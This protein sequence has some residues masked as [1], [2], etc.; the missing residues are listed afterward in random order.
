MSDV[1]PY[2]YPIAASFLRGFLVR[3][4]GETRKLYEIDLRIYFDWCAAAGIDPLAARRAD[5]ETFARYLESERGNRPS[6]VVHRLGVLRM[7][8]RVAAADDMITRDPTVL[9]NMPRAHRDPAKLTWLDRYEMGRMMRVASETSPAHEALVALMGVLG[10]RVSEACAV[11]VED[12]REEMGYRVL[13]IIGKGDKPATMPVPPPTW[14]TLERA[15]DG[16]SSGPL[17]VTKR[18][19]RQTRHGAYDW[20]KRLAKK[21][22]LRDG[23]H[24][25]SLR[26]SAIT[27]A[28]DAGAELRDAQIF[29]RHA[30]PRTTGTYDRRS[31]DLDRHAAHAVA[32][33]VHT[34]A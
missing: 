22:G 10:L 28:L 32:R 29:A 13:S 4:K 5:V 9:L 7:F 26:A 18:G 2:P 19:N 16:R 34:A 27:A 23:L 8:Y 31:F 33:W 30:D 24:P 21:A 11:N 3:Y 15:I 25:H 20:I 12:F 14:R 1:T 6:T 17:I